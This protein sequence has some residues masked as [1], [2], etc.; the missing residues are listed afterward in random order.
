MDAR[1]LELT[2]LTSL[3]AQT[4]DPSR[5]EFAVFLARLLSDA[6]QRIVHALFQEHRAYEYWALQ[7]S[8]FSLVSYDLRLLENTHT[9]ISSEA[10]QEQINRNRAP[11]QFGPNNPIRVILS[12]KEFAS[13][14]AHFKTSNTISFSIPLDHPAFR[15]GLAEV[16]LRQ[17]QVAVKGIKTSNNIVSLHLVHHGRSRFLDRSRKQVT[18]SHM[19]HRT[20]LIYKIGSGPISKDDDNLAQGIYTGLSPFAEW[21]LTVSKEENQNPDLEHVSEIALDFTGMF[22][23]FNV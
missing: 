15:L 7:Y 17:V 23:P 16:S 13:E 11:Q 14:F 20:Q 18:F 5:P 10:L 21:S 2:R 12:K 1:R 22:F 3:L 9:F 4:S 19:P 6:K 8:D